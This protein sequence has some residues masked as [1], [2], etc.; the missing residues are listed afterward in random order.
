MNVYWVEYW[1]DLELLSIEPGRYV[2][3]RQEQGWSPDIPRFWFANTNY[4]QITEEI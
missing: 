2:Q 1:H 3:C 4:N